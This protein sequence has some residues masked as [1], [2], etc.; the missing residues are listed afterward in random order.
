[1][2][3]ELIE[4]NAF[5]ALCDYGNKYKWCWNLF[6]TTCGHYDFRIGF[7][8][9]IHGI[10]PDSDEFWVNKIARTDDNNISDERYQD[11]YY[12]ERRHQDLNEIEKYKDFEGRASKTAQV[13]LAKIVATANLDTIRKTCPGSDWLGY[14][15]LVVE[16]CDNKEAADILSK[17]LIPQFVNIV[18]SK[19]LAEFLQKKLDDGLHLSVNDLSRIEYNSKDAGPLPF[20]RITEL[21]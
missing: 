16:A 11:P 2:D 19:E 12:V 13:K 21:I 7:S 4:R 20:P 8:K 18:S 9:L 15:G 17:S 10:N 5:E 1:M 6:C 3:N 14:L